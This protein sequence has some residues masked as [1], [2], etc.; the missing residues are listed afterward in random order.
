MIAHAAEAG[1][2][3]GRVVVRLGETAA[4]S[5]A[6][7]AAA[8]HVARAFR[9]EVEAIFAEHPDIAAAAAHDRLRIV[10]PHGGERS[11]LKAALTIGLNH[12]ATAGARELA[13]HAR[14][15]GVSFSTKVVRDDPIAALSAACVERGPWNIVA[16]AEPITSPARAAVLNDALARVW[17]TTAFIATGRLAQW[18][19]GPILAVVEDIERLT[20]L[21]RTAERLAALTGEPV[22]VLPAASDVIGQDWLEGE[23]A[24]TLAP[25]A[26][27]TVLPRPAFYGPAAVLSEI[28]R[29]RPRLVLA[30]HGGQVIP[31]EGTHAALAALS[32]PAFIL[33]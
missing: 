28:E 5:H 15:A 13:G 17:G 9:S 22:L 4:A 8:V 30:R 32:A 20:G 25:G 14:S 12:F 2:D 3:R 29:H 11:V 16:F 1:E 19:P 24:L 23:V 26:G 31:A 27:T 21:V 10:A 33:H 18:R 6:A 7:L